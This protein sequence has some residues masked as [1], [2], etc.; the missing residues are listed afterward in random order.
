MYNGSVSYMRASE[1]GLLSHEVEAWLRQVKV[2]GLL[3]GDVGPYFPH[4][5]V[6]FWEKEAKNRGLTQAVDNHQKVSL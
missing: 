5:L 4:P 3:Q 1:K 2:E 6:L